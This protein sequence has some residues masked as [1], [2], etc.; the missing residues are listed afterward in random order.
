MANYNDY[1]VD[2]AQHWAKHCLG[3]PLVPFSPATIS[4]ASKILWFCKRKSTIFSC[5][6][7]KEAAR[8]RERERY[9]D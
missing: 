1:D 4:R 6:S 3:F 5:R 8:N 9:F 2:Y 7:T